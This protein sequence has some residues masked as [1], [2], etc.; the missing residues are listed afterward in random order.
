MGRRWN[1]LCE[2]KDICSKQPKD[3]QEV[4]V[5]LRHYMNYQQ[6]YWIEWLVAVRFQYNDK[7]HTAT[8]RILFELNFGQY[9]WK[10]NLTV[11][12]ELPKLEDFLN[13]LQRSWKKAKKL[14]EIEKKAMKRQ[15]D[16]KRRN[17]QGLK[18]EDNVWLEAKNIHLNRLFKKLD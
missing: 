14:M 6:D 7:R 2:R 15:F 11:K 13:R 5:F 3:N 10:D 12:T 1:C 18:A 16:K 8:G 9:P 4:K 17:L